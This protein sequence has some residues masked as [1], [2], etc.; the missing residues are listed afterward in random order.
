M[1]D[2]CPTT[3]SMSPPK[4]LCLLPLLNNLC[5]FFT[6]PLNQRL[7]V[8]SLVNIPAGDSGMAGDGAYHRKLNA[9]P[10]LNT[11]FNLHN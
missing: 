6:F 2:H 10:A 8:H 5:N 3:Q 1:A 11:Y 7:P 9:R 4:P